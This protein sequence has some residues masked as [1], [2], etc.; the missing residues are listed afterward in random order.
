[1]QKKGCQLVLAFRGPIGHFAHYLS[2]THAQTMPDL[3]AH[4]MPIL[5][6]TRS[7]LT[8]GAYRFDVPVEKKFVAHTAMG[9]R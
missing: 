1:M 4:T 5:L 7:E 8:H 3:A 9:R 2:H 6:P